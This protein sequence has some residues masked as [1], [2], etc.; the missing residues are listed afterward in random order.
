[1][2]DK[3]AG[4]DDLR[5]FLA[6]AREGGL[7]PAARNTQSSPAT[8]ARRMLALE[9][10]LGRDLFVRHDRGY[11]LTADGRALRDQLADV[12]NII[13]DVTSPP[14]DV[15]RPLIKI[16]A[17]T[18]TTLFLLNRITTLT[19]NP[20]DVQLRFV[21][22]EAILDMPHREVAI[23]LRSQR[24]E[25]TN[26]AGKKA[27]RVQFAPYALADAPDRWIKVIAETPSA[28]WINK[29][30]GSDAICEVTA[31]RN[32]LDLALAG[33]GIALLPTFIGNSYPSLERRG[34]PIEEL[35]HDQ[36][37]VTHQDDRHRPDVRR[38]L[39]RLY[40]LF[41]AT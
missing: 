23:G 14:G 3:K 4:W 10:A 22:S 27:G 5:F 29:M 30:V 28:R 34:Q 6:V 39:Q 37:I 21:S 36:W 40:Q 2:N 17:G 26:L 32:G 25:E 20:P 15:S 31:P 11:E 8:L 16:S 13:S 12:E 19:A 7:S 41:D 18:W 1:M 9:R 24:P 38:V 35:A 33:I